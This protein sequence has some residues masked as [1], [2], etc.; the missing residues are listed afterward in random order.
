M[1]AYVRRDD[2]E[3]GLT[4]DDEEHEAFVK[5][6]FELEDTNFDGKITWQ[7]FRNSVYIDPYDYKIDMNSSSV[8]TLGRS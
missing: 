1:S 6:L 2:K 4:T 7:E 3:L 5:H 8:K